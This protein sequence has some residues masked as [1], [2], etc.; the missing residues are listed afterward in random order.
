[1][2]T[3]N[4]DCEPGKT[5]RGW[6]RRLYNH[7]KNEHCSKE[8]SR[9]NVFSTLI[10]YAIL[11]G[12]GWIFAGVLSIFALVRKSRPSIIGSFVIFISLYT[13]FLFVFI[14]V[15]TRVKKVEEDCPSFECE[16]YEEGVERSA[17]SFLSLSICATI[18]IFLS[19]ICTAFAIYSTR[20]R[21]NE[22]IPRE[23]SPYDIQEQ[24]KAHELMNFQAGNSPC[25]LGQYRDN[26]DVV[27][28]NK[29]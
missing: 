15:W 27:Y 29:V 19:S 14:S 9:M 17:R 7:C 3:I 4:E 18:L 21:T 22:S 10:V 16:E 6:F 2:I 1:V 11:C 25:E 28:G 13:F 24:V 23:P 20:D 8:L 5:D 26:I 12:F